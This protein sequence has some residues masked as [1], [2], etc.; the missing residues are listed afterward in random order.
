MG[1][2]EVG[3]AVR[4]VEDQRFITGSGHYVADLNRPVQTH[5]YFIRCPYAH[6]LIKSI[7]AASA[8]T[9]PGVLAVINGEDLSAAKLG[10]LVCGWMVC[11]KDGSPMKMAPHPPLA[12]GKACYVG[13]PVSV[14]IAETLAQARDAAEKVVVEYQVLW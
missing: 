4:R 10:N 6:A 13:E 9:M 8:M 5:A 3:T 7:N 1:G 12:V 11:S 2:T 14:V